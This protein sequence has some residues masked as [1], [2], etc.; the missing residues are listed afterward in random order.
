MKLTSL[1]LTILAFIPISVGADHTCASFPGPIIEISNLQVKDKQIK[2][3]WN[4]KNDSASSVFVFATFL[5]GPNA[6][7]WNVTKDRVCEI[8]AT[9][10]VKMD[11]QV[12]AY[13]G[14]VFKEIKPQGM[15]SGSFIDVRPAVPLS[16][17]KKALLTIG[18]G[19][20]TESI[21]QALQRAYTES[22]GF[23]G[24]PIVDWQC[25]A[26]SREFKMQ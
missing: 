9:H 10:P 4:I 3:D 20:E 8:F 24:N 5:S 22:R 11:V 2:F 6:A 19:F 7:A 13:P 1:V 26:R 15:I 18:Y 25:I 12:N 23:L 14:P 21:K 17:C 16:K